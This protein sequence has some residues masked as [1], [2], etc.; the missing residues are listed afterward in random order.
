MGYVTEHCR[1]AG[2]AA[3]VRAMSVGDLTSLIATRRPSN[4]TD[5]VLIRLETNGPMIGVDSAD[6]T[7][8]VSL[9]VALRV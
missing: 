7:T 4:T 5:L 6:A 9:G 2:N 1:S 3:S 8:L